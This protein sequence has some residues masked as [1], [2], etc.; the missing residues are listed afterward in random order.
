MPSIVGVS[1]ADTNGEPIQNEGVNNNKDEEA[2]AESK[3]NSSPSPTRAVDKS[4]GAVGG[5]KK[6]GD[7]KSE[8]TAA[9]QGG[10]KENDTHKNNDVSK[11]P[12]HDNSKNP[13]YTDELDG[14][15][16]SSKEGAHDVMDEKYDGESKC[17]I[18]GEKTTASKSDEKVDSD[19]KKE[20]NSAS[21][22]E[23]SDNK[24][25]YSMELS[26]GEKRKGVGSPDGSLESSSK[27]S[28]KDDNSATTAAAAGA[29]AESKE[30]QQEQQQ[31]AQA[32]QIMAIQQQMAMQQQAA[33]QMAAHPQMQ[34]AAYAQQQQINQQQQVYWRQQ[35]N[36]WQEPINLANNNKNSQVESLGYNFHKVVLTLPPIQRELGLLFDDNHHFR[37]PELKCVADT[38]PIL[39]QLPKQFHKD[40]CIASMKAE[41]IGHVQP[42]S[43]QHCSTL[44][45][46]AQE[47][48][49][50]PRTL[51]L[52]VIR[53]KDAPEMMHEPLSVP[54]KTGEKGQ[55]NPHDGV[56]VEGYSAKVKPTK[57]VRKQGPEQLE[58]AVAK[59][60]ALID[61]FNDSSKPPYATFFRESNH[62]ESLRTG[63]GRVINGNPRLKWLVS[64]RDKSEY[65]QEACELIDRLLPYDTVDMTDYDVLKKK[66]LLEFFGVAP[67]KK[68]SFQ[69]L[70]LE[71]FAKI[72]KIDRKM[73]NDLKKTIQKDETLCGLVNKEKLDKSDIEMARGIVSKVVL[74]PSAKALSEKDKFDREKKEALLDFF[75]DSSGKTFEQFCNEKVYDGKLRNTI[76]RYIDNDKR[77]T[78][79][80]DKRDD[81]VRR[82]RAFNVIEELL[83]EIT[84]KY[85]KRQDPN[86]DGDGTN[87]DTA[88]HWASGVPKSHRTM[89]TEFFTPANIKDIAAQLNLDARPRMTRDGSKEI[90]IHDRRLPDELLMLLIFDLNNR[91]CRGRALSFRERNTVMVASAK[92]LFYDHGYKAV[93]GVSNLE[94]GWEQRLES[95]YMTGSEQRPLDRLYQGKSSYT[96]NIEK[97]HPGLLAQIYANTEEM[98]GKEA[99][100]GEKA[101]FMN[102]KSMEDN[103]DDP[104]KPVLEMNKS[105][106]AAW[107]KQQKLGRGDPAGD[108]SAAPQRNPDSDLSL[109]K[110]DKKYPGSIEDLYTFA[111][112]AMGPE[113]SY[114]ILATCM[115]E[116]AKENVEED[117]TLPLVTVTKLTLPGWIKKK[118]V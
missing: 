37:L 106:L 43:A 16:K 34:M 2:K 63:F 5:E 6:G 59:K 72:N 94:Q 78:E 102:E 55:K 114:H 97:D 51:E 99:P 41:N 4:D 26:A 101:M 92:I 23:N 79:I 32:A 108:E 58:H 82:E 1:C 107:I 83:S 74:D 18:D 88:T 110:L 33:I 57:G 42:K 65:R 70:R 56:V 54:K 113:A 104:A 48:E 69:L 35:V 3:S 68:S 8:S 11:E 62:D 31:Q 105:R 73:Q 14:M 90:M 67:Q 116:R 13:P 117:P 19:N 9:A 112:E 22:K 71:V 98:I 12:T 20:N 64:M 86:T 53:T 45:T 10:N 115:N 21:D 29:M 27:K 111:L 24:G 93:V 84:T 103:Y 7:A 76:K 39:K 38:S 17:K 96:G 75:S 100:V 66:W 87:I 47:S 28:K 40:I 46:K 85:S 61:F 95:A 30:Q 109:D 81:P 50:T 91:A 52:V 77:L 89:A 49:G 80:L 60:R 15:K 25:G 118:G 36:L 44:L